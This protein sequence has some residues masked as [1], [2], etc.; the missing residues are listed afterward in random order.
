MKFSFQCSYFQLFSIFSKC[1]QYFFFPFFMW[2]FLCS[3]Y[4]PAYVPSLF[5]SMRFKMLSKYFQSFF[6]D[7]FIFL[8]LDIV[9]ISLWHMFLPCSFQ[10]LPVRYLHWGAACKESFVR[11]FFFKYV[12]LFIKLILIKIL[13]FFFKDANNCPVEVAKL[14]FFLNSWYIMNDLFWLFF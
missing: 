8:F 14:L 1:F 3:Q 2:H 5:F 6:L 9:E 11:L 12:K 13:K 7:N 10:C 4:R